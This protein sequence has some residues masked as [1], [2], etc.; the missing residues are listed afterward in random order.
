MILL[1][2]TWFFIL[3]FVLFF[4][5]YYKRDFAN[6][7]FVLPICFLG[8]YSIII[9]NIENWDIDSY[10]YDWETTFCVF[11]TII[12]F[13]FGCIVISLFSD[14]K[15]VVKQ[16]IEN[17]ISY[18]GLHFY[19]YIFFDLLAVFLFILFL[20]YKIRESSF[21]SLLDFQNIVRNFYD[22][23][24][25]YNFFTTQIFESLTALAY[26]SF[27]R[28]MLEKHYIEK[29]SIFKLVL[30]IVIFLFAVLLY[31]D[32]NVFLRFIIFAIFLYIM[33]H[34]W[35]G[36]NIKKNRQLAINVSIIG[37][38][39]TVVFWLYG[40]LKAYTSNLERMIGIYAGSGIYAFNLWLQNFD[41]GYTEGA[42]TLS[43]V[44][45]SLY[46][47]GIGSGSDI[48][49]KWEFIT[50]AAENGYVFSTNIY[51]ALRVYYQDF[52]LFGLVIIPFLMGLF[53][54]KL[55]W[56]ATKGRFGF[57]WLFYAAHIYHVVYFPISEQFLL[58]FHFGLVYE[59]FWLYFFYY[60]LY[61][62]YG[63]WRIKW[64]IF[65]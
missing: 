19:P 44:L 11:L 33:S 48:N 15:L 5:I 42:V 36:I 45:R 52:G 13:V 9:Y 16:N 24:K 21:S 17:D 41:N 31:T 20:H 55:Y 12:S 54:E 63:F 38:V 40:Y 27:H 51:S 8:T 4:Y 53:F 65:P 22:T 64:R 28:I 61:G 3:A 46:A 58:R 39:V 29:H 35:K 30:P 2:F 56:L 25:E 18:R 60:L 59:I 26:I 10:G 50:Y 34:N 7:A 57:W 14:R 37:V 32:R 1:Y 49:Q 62:K 6:P 23:G 43:S 47:L